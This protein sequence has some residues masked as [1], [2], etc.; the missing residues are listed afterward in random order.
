MS[1]RCVSFYT[2]PNGLSCAEFAILY[3]AVP[4]ALIW[5]KIWDHVVKGSTIWCK[6]VSYGGG[7]CCVMKASMFEMW[8]TIPGRLRCATVS[9]TT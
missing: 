3:C 8:L 7:R 6:L 2:F 5:G 4:Y 9:D 1:L